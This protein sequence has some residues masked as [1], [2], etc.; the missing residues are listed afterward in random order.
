MLVGIVKDYN[1]DALCDCFSYAP[2]AVGSNDN[3][4]SR[5]ETLVHHCL[6][7]SVTSQHDGGRCAPVEDATR[8]PRRDGR[9]AGPPHGKISYAQNGYRELL[10]ANQLSVIELLARG[11]SA[12]IKNLQR[13]KESA[14]H[15]RPL[16]LPK[17]DRLGEAAKI[18]HGRAPRLRSSGARSE[19][20]RRQPSAHP[21]QRLW[22]ELRTR[23]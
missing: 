23:W 8:H 10:G 6:I 9:L 4:N 11:N 5:V 16:A 19:E 15:T 14:R 21:A 20:P 22:L 1:I 13:R 17:P 12:A 7:A 3:G 2:N 18:T